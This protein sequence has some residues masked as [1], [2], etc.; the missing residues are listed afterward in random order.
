MLYPGTE[1]LLAVE[2]EADATAEVC[3]LRPAVRDEDANALNMSFCEPISQNSGI[4]WIQ[5]S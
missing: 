1:T 5:P 2:L 3:R 4:A